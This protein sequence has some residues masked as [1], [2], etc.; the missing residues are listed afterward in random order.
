PDVDEVSGF[1]R[2]L[3][4]RA[5]PESAGVSIESGE[6]PLDDTPRREGRRAEGPRGV[7]MLA[8]VGQ[9]QDGKEREQQG[10]RQRGSEESGDRPSGKKVSSAG[11]AVLPRG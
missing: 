8:P 2:E 11:G 9:R 1:Q 4:V 6:E 7:E 3:P 10:R 5:F